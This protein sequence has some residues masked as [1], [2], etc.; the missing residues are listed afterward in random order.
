MAT[1]PILLVWLLIGA[2]LLPTAFAHGDVYADAMARADKAG[3]LILFVYSEAVGSNY[4]DSAKQALLARG[5]RTV[6]ARM[7]VQF[8][9]ID[10]TDRRYAHYR[11]KIE[12][13]D[14]PFWALA[15]PSGEFL[16]GGDFDT[17]T[18][19]GSGGWKTTVKKFAKQYPPIGSKDRERIAKVLAQAQIDLDA[20][21]LG[22]VQPSLAKLEKV[23]HPKGLADRC[24][25]LRSG[26]ERAARNLTERPGQLLAEGKALEAALAYQRIAD[27]FRP[28][29]EE[30]KNARGALRDLLAEYPEL[31]A[32]FNEELRLQ[33][34]RAAAEAAAKEQAKTQPADASPTETPPATAPTTAP[35]DTP[36]PATQARRADSLLKVAK[37]FHKQDMVDR[38]K[39]KLT[40]CIE[41]YPE[42]EAA[43]E[44]RRLLIQW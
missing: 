2:S 13:Q 8:V 39:D 43:D 3:T 18:Q 33:R 42:T 29:S 40:E 41:K 36:D 6:T 9:P 31:R 38:A 26:Y 22:N 35:A 11:S 20:R 28:S 14:Y 30:S 12:G 5:K 34:E 16:A 25:A 23:W 4:S 10:N 44:A 37:Q 27:A 1:R 21:R 15:K 24:A 7:I 32:P 17:V 19:D